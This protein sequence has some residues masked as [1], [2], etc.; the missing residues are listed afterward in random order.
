MGCH[1]DPHAVTAGGTLHGPF[2]LREDLVDVVVEIVAA[3]QR[4]D[5]RAPGHLDAAVLEVVHVYD[6]RHAAQQQL[7]DAELHAQR[8]VV[9]RLPRLEGPDVVVQPRHQR[10]VVGI[11]A[12]Q[13]HGDVAMGIDKAR[14][15]ELAAAVDLVQVG[16]CRTEVLRRGI[17]R[18][19]ERN[20]VADDSHRSRKGTG[21]FGRAGHRQHGGMRK[22]N[23]IHIVVLCFWCGPPGRR[24]AAAP[25]GGGGDDA[26][27]GR[28]FLPLRPTDRTGFVIC[29]S[30]WPSRP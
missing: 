19:D 15:D 12:L 10:D 9:G 25:A 20:A 4:A 2:D 1:G 24:H 11:A 29:I 6:R 22:E 23:G 13:R 30:P 7:G 28:Y 26:R 18:R 16:M 3:E 21:G 8:H 17:R 14:H 27:G 5:A